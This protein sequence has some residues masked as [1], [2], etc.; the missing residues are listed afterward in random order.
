MRLAIAAIWL[1]A[2]TTLAAAH[3]DPRVATAEFCAT[4]SDSLTR[5]YCF[6]NAFP[7]VDGGLPSDAPSDDETWTLEDG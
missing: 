7:P 2:S 5:L 4:I 1:V 3:D 6:D